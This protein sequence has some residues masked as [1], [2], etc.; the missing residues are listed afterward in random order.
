LEELV[1]KYAR[2]TPATKMRATN[3]TRILFFYKST[4]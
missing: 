4:F 2:I 3:R 1:K